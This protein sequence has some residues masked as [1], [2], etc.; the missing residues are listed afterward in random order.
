M[1]ART[2]PQS[3]FC[4]LSSPSKTDQIERID[5]LIC[6][7]VDLAND[8]E[9]DSE[10]DD[11]GFQNV[12]LD[13]NVGD[14]RYLLIRKPQMD[15]SQL[16]LSPREREIVELVAHGHPTK[17]IAAVLNISCWTVS[18]HLRRIFIKLGVT[19]RLAMIAR[20]T[21]HARPDKTATKR[22]PLS[23]A[24]GDRGRATESYAASPIVRPLKRAAHAFSE[25][26]ERAHEAEANHR[27]V[28]LRFA[29]QRSK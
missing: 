15:S 13:R 12:I 29:D 10:T 4:P 5:K 24:A 22:R 1:K 19:S 21:E 16:P 28:R 14:T 8:C 26:M 2:Q 3:P 23:E 9:L 17:V 25:S 11:L 18:A 20:L 27:E 6:V 7:L